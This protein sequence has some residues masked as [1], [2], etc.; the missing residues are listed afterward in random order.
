MSWTM[1]GKMTDEEL[2][3]AGRLKRTGRFYVFLREVLPE[4][5]DEGFVSELTAAYTPRGQEPLPPALLATVTLLQAYDQAS[6]A[7]AVLNAEMD[8]RWQLVLGIVGAEQAPFSQGTLPDFRARMMEHGL[9]QKLLT[10]TVDVAKRSGKF[11]WQ[12]LKVALDSSPLL[13]AGRVLDSWNLLGKALQVLVT[14]VAVG[15]GMSYEAVCEA[16]SL[17]VLGGKSLKAQLDLDWNDEYERQAGLSRVVGE[18][19]WLMVWVEAQMGARANQSPVKE[20]LESLKQLLKQDY[21]LAKK[22][23]DVQLKQGVARDRMPSLGDK[24]MR[25]GRKSASKKFVGY[26]RHIASEVE[27]RLILAAEVLPAN[28]AEH[29]A[30]PALIAQSKKAGTIMSLHIDRGYLA[31]DETEQLSKD[32]ALVL[33]RAWPVRDQ[34]L[35]T[36]EDFDVRLKEERVVCP[37]R[38]SAQIHNGKAA[39]QATECGPCPLRAKCT[40]SREGAGR[41]IAI[42]SQEALLIDLR[43]SQK[44]SD[45][46]AAL[47]QRVSVEHRLARVDQVQ[48]HRARYKGTRRNTLDLRRCAAVINLQEIDRRQRQLA[49]AA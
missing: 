32:G 29:E 38:H 17:T 27:N 5:F 6:D 46:R 39:F 9:D 45:G 1:P 3:I 25:H 31:S 23:G 34:G 18:T 44:T 2:K 20:A 4:L 30:A 42:H 35:F 37:G 16:A 47:R 43:A 7:D 8:K 48:G 19:M 26:K 14:C 21:E 41:T 10:R 40:T 13:G 36:K 28:V 12:K 33:C 11:G 15:M 49:L 24:E 22:G